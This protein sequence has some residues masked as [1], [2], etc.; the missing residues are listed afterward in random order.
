MAT[1]FP[2]TRLVFLASP[3]NPV[4]ATNTTEEI[5]ALVRAL[6]PHVIL[7]MDEATSSVDT[8]TE[9]RL[10]QRLK[11]EFAGRTLILI[12]HKLKLE[13]INEG[14]ALMKRGESIRSVVEF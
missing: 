1:E 5:V 9:A 10:M 2:K 11:G 12:T 6:P 13:D 4:G 8:E 14:F 3:A 7:V